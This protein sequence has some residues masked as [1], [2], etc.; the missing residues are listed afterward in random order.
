MKNQYFGDINDFKKYGLIR[1]LSGGGEISTAVCWM[2]TDDDVGRDGRKTTYLS[3]AGI[4]R[5][6]D[7]RLFDSLKKCLRTGRRD[8]AM[9]ERWNIIPSAA[10]YRRR[11]ADDAGVRRE[12]FSEFFSI[13]RENDLIFFDPDNGMEVRS[14]PLGRKG[15]SKYLYWKE[16]SYAF[17]LGQSVLIY[18]HFPRVKREQFTGSIVSE[19]AGCSRVS[20]VISFRTSN[21]LFLLA[22]QKKHRNYFR[23]RARELGR[24]WEPHIS[25]EFH[26]R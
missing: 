23:Q 2:L 26:T 17:G 16:F 13:C 22:V 19:I 7:P 8:V 3:Q 12:Y 21:V 18:Q 25:V 15:S 24:R 1:A 6:L 14:V 9:A 11:L 5:S 4:Y 20:C 10:Y